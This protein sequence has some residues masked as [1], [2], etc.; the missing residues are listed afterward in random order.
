MKTMPGSVCNFWSPSYY[1]TACLVATV[2]LKVDIS[3]A[4]ITYFYL[5]LLSLPL[6]LIIRSTVLKA[7]TLKVGFARVI[8]SL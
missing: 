6:L 5:C 3:D 1:F 4:F 2:S 7:T 8:S